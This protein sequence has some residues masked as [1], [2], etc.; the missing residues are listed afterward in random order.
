ME[1]WRIEKLQLLDTYKE[2]NKSAQKGQTVFAGSSLMEMFPVE[3]WMKELGE[4]AP[5]VYNR[6]VGGYTTEDYLPVLDIC[7]L[8]LAPK[9]VFI[10]IGT[11]DLNRPDM[12]IDAIM[13]NYEQMIFQ[14]KQQNAAVKIYL[15]AYYPVNEVVATPEIK[16]CLKVRTN[17]KIAQANAAVQ[18]LA[19]KHGL[20][21]IDVTAPLKDAQGRLKAEYTTEGMHIKPEGYRAIFPLVVPYVME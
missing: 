7:V 16:E 19:Q 12:T 11:N 20:A 5:V 15:M 3:E 17:E 9:K 18:S 10:N 13:A 21:F 2:M 6:G 4:A 8:D 1:Q 14:I